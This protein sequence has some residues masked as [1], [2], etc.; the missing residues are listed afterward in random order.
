MWRCSRCGESIEDAFERCWKCG[1]SQLGEVDAEFTTEPDDPSIPDPDAETIVAGPPAIASANPSGMTRQEIA[2]LICR[3]LALIMFAIAAR[4]GLVALLWLT[5][6]LFSAPFRQ[7]NDWQNIYE[8]AV[9]ALPALIL[10]IIGTLYWKLSGTIAA[11]MVGQDPQPVTSFR[12]TA[13]DL[14]S[15]IFSA[16]GLYVVVSS[17]RE[18][19]GFIYLLVQRQM[20]FADFANSQSAWELTI[21]MVLGVWLILGSR[22]IVQAVLWLRNAGRH[23]LDTE[24]RD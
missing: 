16:I 13:T 6:S 22:G 10:A 9:L 3:T 14:M 17:I 23:S 8:S 12:I 20:E 2:A 7:W 4:A 15:V 24:S 18:V 19:V 1:T 5:V 11:A 21:Q